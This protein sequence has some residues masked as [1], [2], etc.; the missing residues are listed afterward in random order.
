MDF[1]KLKSEIYLIYREYE[2]N[3]AYGFCA[4]MIYASY[5]NDKIS[6]GQRSS[7]DLINR[8]TFNGVL[9]T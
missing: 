8:Q 5:V 3:Y 1:E 9:V 7:L 6:D 4:G 2:S